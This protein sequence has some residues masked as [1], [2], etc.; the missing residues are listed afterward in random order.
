MIPIQYVKGDATTPKGNGVKI[1]AHIDNN[2]GGWGRGFVLSI[3]KRWKEPE[4]SYREWYK[5]RHDNDFK[6]GAVQFVKVE[7]DI[8]VANMIG[9]HEVF[10]QDGIPPIR[11]DAVRE[12]LQRVY[13]FA[14]EYNG[15]IHSP[16]FGSGHA[17][18]NWSIIEAIIMEELS[19]KDVPVFIYDIY[20]SAQR[21]PGLKP[22][23]T[24]NWVK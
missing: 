23:Q 20:V 18:G 15:S 4:T 17:G 16:R 7:N 12:C 2:V 13:S 8:Y 1:I 10:Q 9:Q 11:Y 14:K 21:P 24:R 5:N 19:S 3:S 6:L 22:G